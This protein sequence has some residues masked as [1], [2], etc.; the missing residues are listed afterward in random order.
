MPPNTKRKFTPRLK[1]WKLTDPQRRNH[2]Q[3]VFR[4][5]VSAYAGVPDAATEDIWNNLKTGLLKTTEV[6]GTTR[7][8]RWCCETWWWNEHVGEVITAKWQ[9]FK[10]WKTG[11]GTRASYH[12][13]KRIARCAVHHACLEADKE[14]YKNIDP[15]SSELY[16]LANQFRKENADVEGHKLVKND[17]REMSISDDS[18]QKAWLEHYQRL[19]N[20]EFDW[21]PNHLSDESPVEGPPIPITVNMVKTTISQMKAGKAPGPSGIVVEM[22]RAAGDMGASMIRDLAAA[23]IRDG[24]V[25]SD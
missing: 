11:K 10:A 4:L 14:V 21:D 8:H 16:C 18:K 15:K 7:P 19:L 9:A 3:E 12:A 13:A 20:A 17:A 23:I 25:P 5:Q 2:F 24:R 22:I 1:V 6:C